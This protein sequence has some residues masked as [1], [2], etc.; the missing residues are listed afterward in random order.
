MSNWIV[1]SQC[2][3]GHWQ[4]TSGDKEC[5]CGKMVYEDGD[6]FGD[7]SPE[8]KAVETTTIDLNKVI[9]FLKENG[10]ENFLVP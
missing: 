6:V 4:D 2:K 10:I 3:C 5:I 1:A 9:P 7:I 8:Y